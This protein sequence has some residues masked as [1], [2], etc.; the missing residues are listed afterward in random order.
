M[1]RLVL[2]G[3]PGTGKSTIARALAQRWGC[4]SADTDDVIALSLGRSAAEV[5]RGE[6]EVAFRAHELLALETALESDGVVATGAG[7]VSIEAARELLKS[8]TTIWLDCDDE[9]L[10]DRVGDGDRPLL[11]DNPRGSLARLRGERTP[12]Y[13]EVSRAR[14]DA[15]GTL[16]DVIDRV[17]AAMAGVQR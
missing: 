1:A 7:V 11:G 9:V 12:W 8:T 13:E 17:V 3:L 6:G 4:P 10:E 16:D 5:L 14:V 15:S 2:V